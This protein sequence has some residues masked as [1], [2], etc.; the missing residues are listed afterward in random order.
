MSSQQSIPLGSVN[1]LLL[2][3]CCGQR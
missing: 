2:L 1:K 3:L